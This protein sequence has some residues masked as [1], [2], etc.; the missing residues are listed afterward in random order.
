MT[1][2]DEFARLVS[3][4]EIGLCVVSLPRPDGSIQSSV[5]SAGVLPHPKGGH[6]VVGFVSRGD[7][8]KLDYLRNRPYVNIVVRVGG[9]WMAA[10]GPVELVGPDDAL[11]GVDPEEL[12]LLLRNVFTASGGT[13]DDWDT[14]DRVMAEEHRTVVLLTPQRVYS[15]PPM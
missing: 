3:E 13:H 10:E 15:N 14:Y 2:L 9:Q 8:R 12:R 5:V 7:A 1:D 11:D 4:V 6:Q